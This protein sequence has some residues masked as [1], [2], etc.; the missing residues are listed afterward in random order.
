[1]KIKYIKNKELKGKVVKIEEK[2][3]VM[4]S[5]VTKLFSPRQFLDTYSKKKKQFSHIAM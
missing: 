5:M 3:I 4:K 2:D 1:M